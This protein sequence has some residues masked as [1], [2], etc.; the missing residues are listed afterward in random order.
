MRKLRLREVNKEKKEK[1]TNLSIVP[2]LENTYLL[3]R[4]YTEE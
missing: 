4:V 2:E 1:K 3:H